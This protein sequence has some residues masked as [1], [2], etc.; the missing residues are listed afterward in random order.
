MDE[1]DIEKLF[2]NVARVSVQNTDAN[3]EV[4]SILVR[5]TLN[6]RDK[7]LSLKGVVVTVEDVRTALGWLIP[8]IATNNMPETDNKIRLGLLQLWLE[9]LMKKE[10]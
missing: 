3:R 9:Q 1:T 10:Y 8:A 4:F 2:R 7:M 5:S 6:Y